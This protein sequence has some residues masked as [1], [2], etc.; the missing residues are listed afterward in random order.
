M[1]QL[2]SVQFACPAY[3][4]RRKDTAA[5][6]TR[7]DEVDISEQRA[8][9]NRRLREIITQD[10]MDSLKTEKDFENFIRQTEHELHLKDHIRDDEM[11]RLKERFRHDRDVTAIRN[12]IEIH[13]I[14]DDAERERAWKKLFAEE[15]ARD[16]QFRRQLQRDLEVVKTDAEK[17]RIKLEIENLEYNERLRQQE[18]AHVQDMKEASDGLDLLARVKQME[19]EEDDAEH[20]RELEKANAARAAELDKLRIQQ[21]MTPEQIIAIAARENPALGSVLVQKYAA[22][23]KIADER[24]KLLEKQLADERR[25][26]EGYADR[27]ERMVKLSLEQMG[28]VAGTR[29]RAEENRQT[30]VTNPLGGAP[31]VIDPRGV[32]GKCKHCGGSLEPGGG[33]CPHCGKGQ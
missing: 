19:R 22:E 18:L 7:E 6:R 31:V 28:M 8:A 26:H 20:R 4:K 30:I 5:V 25:L 12:R 1:V 2:R 9:L 23:G 24:A 17:S 3:E 10:K 33:F 14:E 16:E 32:A 21:N 15:E 27:Q 11:D 13:T 29:A